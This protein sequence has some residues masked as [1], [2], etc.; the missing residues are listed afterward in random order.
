MERAKSF[1][2]HA[3]GRNVPGALMDLDHMT[4]FVRASKSAPPPLGRVPESFLAELRLAGGT[5]GALLGARAF[6]HR[7]TGLS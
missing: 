1:T 3:E 2:C 7:N 4:F 5:T 6:P